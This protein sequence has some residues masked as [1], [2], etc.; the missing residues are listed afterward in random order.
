MYYV[1]HESTKT[2]KNSKIV[3]C[4][5]TRKSGSITSKNVVG[6]TPNYQLNVCLL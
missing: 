4:N 2:S 3:I 1:C 6:F 5:L